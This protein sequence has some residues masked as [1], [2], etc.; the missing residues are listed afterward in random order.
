MVSYA[1]LGGLGAREGTPVTCTWERPP[2]PPPRIIAAASA[3]VRILVALLGLLP[4]FLFRPNRSSKAWWIWLPVGTAALVGTAV[5]FLMT[6]EEL[7]LPQAVCAFVIGL[8]S[9]WLMMP[10]LKGRRGIGTFF[11]TFPVL[12]GFSLLG[13][14]PASFAEGGGW[15]DVRPYLAT[16]LAV[17][18]MAATL[19]L[20]FT[21]LAVRRRF[22][23][24]RCIVWLAVWTVLAWTAI[25]T[26]F[27]IVGSVNGGNDWK[28]GLLAIL[29]LSA[30]LLGLVLPLVLLSFFQPFYRHRFFGWLNLPQPEPTAGTAV[31]P[32]IPGA[33]QPE[34]TATARLIEK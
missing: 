14:V 16:L 32:K 12:A 18:S 17:A 24:V 25:A 31:P 34:G 2:P 27:A 22:G 4:L 33:Y 5:A 7:S 26:P 8:A 15:I 13:F 29:S 30:I 20:V 19:A 11:K 3:G 28:A 6:D 9:V 1:D 21:G 10:Y 23:R